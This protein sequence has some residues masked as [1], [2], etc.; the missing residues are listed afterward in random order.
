M[1]EAAAKSVRRDI[2]RAMGPIAIATLDQHATAIQT[3]RLECEQL[4]SSKIQH[5]D[6]LWRL[7]E[8]ADALGK[9]LNDHLGRHPQTFGQRLR[10][11]VLGR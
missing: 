3:L 8:R 6:G 1:S 7:Q 5:A 9:Q 4:I 11:L 10:W 2:R